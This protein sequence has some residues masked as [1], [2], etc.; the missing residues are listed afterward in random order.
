MYLPVEK[1]IQG[2]AGSCGYGFKDRHWHDFLQELPNVFCA[3]AASDYRTWK[4]QEKE[5]EEWIDTQYPPEKRM[6]I[7]LDQVE[8]VGTMIVRDD[9]QGDSNGQ[10]EN[11]ELFHL[12]PNR[13]GVPYGPN[14]N[15]KLSVDEQEF[16]SLGIFPR[17]EQIPHSELYV[18]GGD[19]DTEG[20]YLNKRIRAAPVGAA[21]ILSYAEQ[22]NGCMVGQSSTRGQAQN[23][24][25]N[26]LNWT[27]ND[28]NKNVYL[29]RACGVFKQRTNNRQLPL[30]R[31]IS[32]D[33]AG[34]N[35][36]RAL[37]GLNNSIDGWRNPSTQSDFS[38]GVLTEPH[39]IIGVRLKNPDKYRLINT[40]AERVYDF[41]RNAPEEEEEESDDETVDN[42]S[43]DNVYNL[44][45]DANSSQQISD[46]VMGWPDIIVGDIVHCETPNPVWRVVRNNDGFVNLEQVEDPTVTIEDFAV[47]DLTFIHRAI[48]YPLRLHEHIRSRTYCR[49]RLGSFQAPGSAA[50]Q[51]LCTPWSGDNSYSEQ[52]FAIERFG[53]GSR[54]P[55][56]Y[57]VVDEN[58]AL[59]N[60]EDPIGET[61]QVVLRYQTD[62]YRTFISVIAYCD[63][64]AL[65]IFGPPD[66]NDSDAEEAAE[67]NVMGEYT[68]QNSDRSIKIGDI[69]MY[70]PMNVATAVHSNQGTYL[71]GTRFNVEDPREYSVVYIIAN[72]DS[73]TFIIKLNM[74]TKLWDRALKKSQ[75]MLG[76][77]DIPMLQFKR[78][79]YM[80]ITLDVSVGRYETWRQMPN[81]VGTLVRRV[82]TTGAYLNDTTYIVTGLTPETG[83][84][85]GQDDGVQVQI[86]QGD[87][88]GTGGQYGNWGVYVPKAGQEYTMRVNTKFLRWVGYQ[89]VYHDN[90]YF[91]IGTKWNIKPQGEDLGTIHEVIAVHRE[92]LG[93]N[94]L[95]GQIDMR[96]QFNGLVVRSEGP[97]A[98][99]QMLNLDSYAG[100]FTKVNQSLYSYSDLIASSW[101]VYENWEEP[102]DSASETSEEDEAY[103]ELD[104]RL[105]KIT[106]KF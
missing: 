53:F 27:S 13:A 39:F 1:S 58:E 92:Y 23:L 20:D 16:V 6:E 98:S 67:E 33:G 40:Q 72:G 25:F 26:P 81:S 63:N 32:R 42:S 4:L 2:G 47:D 76:V 51:A 18:E 73:T 22:T 90:N 50:L 9:R 95:S 38:A 71:R 60:D 46:N 64:A 103:M 29:N 11:V 69:V 44:A 89:G 49:V 34:Y 8:Y 43:G 78:E 17:N 15:F 102:Q 101:P 66:E 70:Q 68:Y 99:I 30:R 62:T 3:E 85:L 88:I 104:S 94:Q 54:D 91:T 56:T 75:R 83:P 31:G 10:I 61:H 65:R 7:L 36:Q 77:M 79:G 41:D 80:P 87:L 5:G 106:L 59:G 21:A 37:F 82:T 48:N 105:S 28:E 19:N 93:A 55:L 74:Y 96:E 86:T 45:I 12:S 97:Y 14:A 57:A 52:V 35:I 24:I 84:W 100:T